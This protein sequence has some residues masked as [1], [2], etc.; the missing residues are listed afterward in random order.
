M[1]TP[2]NLLLVED[3]ALLAMTERLQLER[4]GY[5][6]LHVLSGEAALALLD[7]ERGGVDLV[8]MD[9][10][11]GPGIDG[12]AA[13]EGIL[14]RHDLP[15]IFL[16]SHTEKE[17]VERTE[18]ITNYGYVVKNSGITVLDA[19]IKMAFKLFESRKILK[20]HER[21]LEHNEEQYRLLFENS[22]SAVTLY[23][24]LFDGEGRPSD[25]VYLKVNS[26]YETQTGQ[27][28]QKVLG[29]KA[30]EIYPHWSLTGLIDKYA[31]VIRSGE[32]SCFEMNF[33]P[34]DSRFKITAFPAGP[35]RFATIF[36]NITEKNRAVESVRKGE[37]YYQ[38]I[39]DTTQDGFFTIDE[40]GR[41]AEANGAYCRMTGFARE[42]LLGLR[43]GDIDPFEDPNTTAERLRRIRER[44]SE[45]F[46][47]K[48]R[49]IDG[50]SFNVE[51]SVAWLGEGFNQYIS[52]CR[53]V[54]EK[55]RFE[56]TLAAKERRLEAL[57]EHSP[58]PILEEDF[59]ALKLHFDGLAPAE[60]SDI[61]AYFEADPAR[62][63]AC[64]DLV[65]VL[66]VNRACLSFFGAETKADMLGPLSRRFTPGSAAYFKRELVAIAEGA[67]EFELEM[68]ADAAGGEKVLLLRLTVVPGCE[69]DLRRVIVSFV[70]ITE[71]TSTETRIRELLS[72]RE[73]FIKEIHH[74]VKN[75]MNT[76]FS[77]LMYE[78][79]LLEDKGG[80]DMLQNAAG[81]VRSMGL[82]YEKLYQSELSG[83][84]AIRD[85]F[86][87]FLAEIVALFPPD[88]K[89]AVKTEI[90][91]IALGERVVSP[92]GIL[93]YEL[94]SNSMKYAFRGRE[95]GL[96]RLDVR[97]LSGGIEMRYEDDGVGLPEGVGP[98]QSGGFGMSLIALLARQ[99]GGSL[100]L[101][102]GAG[103][104]FI[105]RFGGG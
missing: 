79:G 81:R 52:F 16:S 85:Y 26:A 1:T 90:E 102:R 42:S 43:I 8:L 95:K 94:A 36:E 31:E 2:K 83:R 49:R 17:I 46:E 27:E 64:A 35:S 15:L 75:N 78:A 28:A 103:T 14:E 23:E 30:S 87:G 100:E 24:M 58:L 88:V 67:R 61:G 69:E 25:Y 6:V 33:V 73:T 56:E 60:R 80:R 54:T 47:T 92:L 66:D 76:V 82:L 34:L 70:D 45:T 53:D 63:L 65:R 21:L 105:L 41:Y 71:R 3:E 20:E 51:L 93:L 13:A 89:V 38:A 91:D 40:E 55:A 37:R 72:E 12:I 4:A 86:P 98:G 32:S 59:S 77:F 10:N 19:S 99:I 104:V 50:S 29:R 68:L 62:I 11:L 97:R 22:I 101:R 48:H 5:S 57:F 96:I 9:I 74:R 39:L 44:G 18:A 7:A 84:I